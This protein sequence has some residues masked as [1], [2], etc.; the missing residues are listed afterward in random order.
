MELT[1]DKAIYISIHPISLNKIITGI[2]NHEFRNYIPKNEFNKL[3]VYV[4]KPIY[5]LKYIIHISEIIKTPNKIIEHGYGNKEFNLGNKSKY[6][7]KIKD[8]YEL[9][10]PI[11]LKELKEIYNFTPPQAFAYDYRYLKLTNRIESS[12]KELRLN[13]K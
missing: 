7:Y 2:K 3:Y 13:N 8:V 4:T 10:K 6:A 1:T 12:E 5:E 11:S 9:K